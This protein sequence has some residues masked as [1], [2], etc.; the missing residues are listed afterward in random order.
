MFLDAFGATA[1]SRSLGK[2]LNQFWESE[3]NNLLTVEI[4]NA[5]IERQGKPDGEKWPLDRTMSWLDESVENEEDEDRENEEG[6]D[7]KPD[8]DCAVA[9]RD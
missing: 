5:M 4:W 8:S 2:V 3:E 6:D 7:G 1:L 9:S